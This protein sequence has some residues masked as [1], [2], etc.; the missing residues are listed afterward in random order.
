MN[1]VSDAVLN[2]DRLSLARLI[3]GIE[4]QQQ[5]SLLL[6]DQLFSHT[7]RAHLIGV[8]GAPGSGKSSLVNQMACLYRHPKHGEP[9][10]SVAVVAIDP[11]SPFTGGALLGDRVR[12][13]DLAGDSGVFIRSMASRGELGGLASTTS[14]V[15]QVLDA[16]GFEVILIETVGVGQ[17]EIDI[18]RLAHTVIVVEA[19]GMGDD[20]QAG[21]AGILEIADLLV[22]NKADQ[23]GADHT[24]RILNQMLEMANSKRFNSE[25]INHHRGEGRRDTLPAMPDWRPPVL[26]TIATE[27]TGIE[28]LV[29]QVSK[30]W[31]YLQASGQRKSRENERLIKEM[32]QLL[33]EE[34]MSHWRSQVA[35]ELYQKILLGL[36]EKTYS[37]RQAVRQLVA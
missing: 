10:K 12:M 2:G 25:I 35:D 32:E 3:T 13:R 14:Q 37:P 33:R 29:D 16:A 21:K 1:G 20:V 4:N 9:E 18:A 5:D 7:G 22:V 28:D 24:Q 34:L 17:S 8:T 30:H 23:N 31:D 15:V 26:K 11:T 27:G 36:L 19:P 6:L